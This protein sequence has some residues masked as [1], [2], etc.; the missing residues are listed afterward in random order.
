MGI[1][2]IIAPVKMPADPNPAIARPVMK[3]SDVGAAAQTMDPISKMK[4]TIKKVLSGSAFMHTQI[5]KCLVGSG[6]TI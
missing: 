4:M 6:P 2:I 5:K 1:I 3:T